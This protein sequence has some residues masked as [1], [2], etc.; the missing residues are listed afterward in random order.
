LCCEQRWPKYDEK[1]IEQEKFLLIVQVNGK[2]RDKI[3]VRSGILQS[4]AE[5]IVNSSEKIRNIIADKEIKKIIFVPNK[6][7]NIVI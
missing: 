7:I 4:E 6:L 2:V 1:V 3:E 5:K